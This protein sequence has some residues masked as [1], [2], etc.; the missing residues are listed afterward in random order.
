MAELELIIGIKD[1][2]ERL[3]T[4]GTKVDVLLAQHDQVTRATSDHELRLRSLERN[5]WPLP[6][7]SVIIAALA[8]FLTIL[9]NYS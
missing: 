1:V 4:V 2:Y 3:V 9:K 8:L 7:L 6:S 5:R